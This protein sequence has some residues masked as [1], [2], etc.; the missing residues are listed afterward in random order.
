ML[1][2]TAVKSQ[3]P[4]L[5]TA[6]IICKYIEVLVIMKIL[7]TYSERTHPINMF[8]QGKKK[9]KKIN[10]DMKMLLISAFSKKQLN[11]SRL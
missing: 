4:V 3:F 2:I 1:L 6:V 10:V 7:H 11:R 8:I 9:R 5:I